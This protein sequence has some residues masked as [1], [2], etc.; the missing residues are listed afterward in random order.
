MP[1][2]SHLR[3][4][5]EE[6]LLLKSQGLAG[7]RIASQLGVTYRTFHAFCIRRNIRFPKTIARKVN[8]TEMLRLMDLGT[9]LPEI[10]ERLGVSTSAITLRY[11][12]KG[13]SIG[14]TGPRHGAG[15]PEWQEGRRLQKHGY[16]AIWVPLHPQASSGGSV[17]EHRLVME[18]V[19]GRMLDRRE[20]PD[21]LDNIPY[22]NW[23]DNLLL[24][25][26]NADHLR[27]ELTGR[28]WATSPRH[29]TPGAYGSTEKLPRCPSSQETLALC[30]AEILARLA[31]YIESFRPT[32]AHRNQA[33]K[34]FLRQG[35]WRDPFQWPSTVSDS[36]SPQ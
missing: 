29:S 30:P 1:R 24:H 36:D 11:R 8:E 10:A 22:H 3:S 2:I 7:N 6:I 21:H 35:A 33:R 13:L 17:Q 32:S 19:L 14:R 25:A 34:E 31:W 23:P 27:R 20:V 12:R 5:I 26:C 28:G 9:T 16:I 18:V 4:R 15:H